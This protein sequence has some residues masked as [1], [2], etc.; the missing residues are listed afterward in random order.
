MSK[1][2]FTKSLLYYY[3]NKTNNTKWNEKTLALFKRSLVEENAIVKKELGD[4]ED[5][6]I[7]NSELLESLPF[8]AKRRLIDEKLNSDPKFFTFMV[9]ARMIILGILRKICNLEGWDYERLKEYPFSWCND[10]SST[11]VKDKH[12]SILEFKMLYETQIIIQG[13]ADEMAEVIIATFNLPMAWLYVLKGYLMAERIDEIGL[14]LRADIHDEH[15]ENAVSR[16]EPFCLTY[17]L[18]K[19]FDEAF[20]ATREDLQRIPQAQC[21]GRPIGKSE[22]TKENYIRMAKDY[23]D[24]CSQYTL[25]GEKPLTQKEFVYDRKD[26]YENISVS[27]LRRALK[28]YNQIETSIN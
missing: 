3:R 10:D 21:G 26:S 8:Q 12:D 1:H 25:Q 6:F 15:D 24:T 20:E 11:I 5:A 16:Y 28:Y 14:V 9:N 7:E 4:G 23:F 17:E 19:Y 22:K 18:D 27:T 13:L 2:K